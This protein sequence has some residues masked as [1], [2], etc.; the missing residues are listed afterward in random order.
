MIAGLIGIGIPSGSGIEIAS[1]VIAGE[2][3]AG[4]AVGGDTTETRIASNNIGTDATGFAALPNGVGIRINTSSLGTPMEIS[5]GDE[6]GGGNRIAYNTADGV[7]ITA[8]GTSAPQGIR[9]RGNSI[10]YNGE[11]G[12]DLG[13]DG[14]TPNDPMDADKGPNRLQ[15]WPVITRVTDDSMTLSVDFSLDSVA[16]TDFAVEIFSSTECDPSGLGEGHTFLAAGDVTTDAMGLATGTVTALFPTA[17]G[18]LTATATRATR[19]PD[20]GHPGGTSEFSECVAIGGGPTISTLALDRVGLAA[21]VATLSLAGLWLRRHFE[22]TLASWRDGE[23]AA[24]M[25]SDPKTSERQPP[26][27]PA[28]DAAA[29]MVKGRRTPST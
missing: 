11:S 2:L 14:P 9:I 28:L 19:A 7:R 21:L 5:V 4:I 8:S 26:G 6:F 15:N 29:A 13:D 22:T 17:A 18:A 25:P 3:I 10:H 16:D 23:I 12:I 24:D 20:T 1:N 27:P